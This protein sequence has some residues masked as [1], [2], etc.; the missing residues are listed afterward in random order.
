MESTR[1]RLRVSPVAARPAVVERRGEARKVR[2]HAPTERG[3]ANQGRIR[4]LAETLS[5]PRA[6]A[7]LVSRRVGRDKIVGLDGLAPSQIERRL[8]S[9]A[10][11]ERRQ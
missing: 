9:A 2:V 5:I 3:R 8:S 11:K 10:R 7:K 4:S 6:A 1:L